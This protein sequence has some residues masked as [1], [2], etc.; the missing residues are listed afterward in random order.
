MAGGNADPNIRTP[1]HI[2]SPNSEGRPVWN[3]TSKIGKE[4]Y[5]QPSR[6][7]PP[8]AVPDIAKDGRPMIACRSGHHPSIHPSTQN[9]NR[10]G[11]RH[12][13]HLTL[14]PTNH[15]LL[16]LAI[17]A[18]VQVKIY[19]VPVPSPSRPPSQSPWFVPKVYVRGRTATTTERTPR[20]GERETDVLASMQPLGFSVSEVLILPRRSLSRN[21]RTSVC[22]QCPGCMSGLGSRLILVRARSPSRQCRNAAPALP[23]ALS[24]ANWPA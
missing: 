15:A 17:Q 12:L 18:R 22:F 19:F 4:L 2:P 11:I 6:P 13:P 10:D 8:A 20:T 7:F 1:L 21:G 16:Y 5:A 14:S 23:I 24:K 9:R 3:G